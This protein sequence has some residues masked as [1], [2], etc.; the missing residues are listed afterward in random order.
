AL[1]P[2]PTPRARVTRAATDGEEEGFAKLHVKRGSDRILG[3]TIVGSHAGELITPLTLAMVAGVGLGS[4]A[5]VISPYPTLAEVLKTT[6]GA[7]TRTRL[8][9]TVKSLFALWF[10]LTS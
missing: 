1:P 9:P 6:A 7:Y 10:R 5:N 3:A 4:F 8:T 2:L